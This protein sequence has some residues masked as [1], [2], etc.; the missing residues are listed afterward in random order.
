MKEK[1]RTELSTFQDQ[2]QYLKL[3]LNKD[4][5]KPER[6]P[7]EDQ[8]KTLSAKLTTLPQVSV[9]LTTALTFV[10]NL[11]LAQSKVPCKM[12]NQMEINQMETK[13]VTKVETKVVCNTAPMENNLELLPNELEMYLNK[14]VI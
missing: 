10:F 2:F 12:L 11:L 4:T 9:L 7:R 14:Q 1:L 8:R 5:V 6:K 13:V 3:L